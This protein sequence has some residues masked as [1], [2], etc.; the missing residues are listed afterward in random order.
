MMR[1]IENF[2]ISFNAYEHDF[3]LT[4][5][6]FCVAAVVEPTYALAWA[7]S[8]ADAKLNKVLCDCVKYFFLL[9]KEQCV[10]DNSHANKY[11]KIMF[12]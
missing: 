10:I 2:V 8:H 6:L 5:H 11:K 1:N 12:N 3:Y 7:A 9:A 4:Y